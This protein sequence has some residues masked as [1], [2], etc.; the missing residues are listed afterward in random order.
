MKIKVLYPEIRT[1]QP[2]YQTSSSSLVVNLGILTTHVNTAEE[3]VYPVVRLVETSTGDV[4]SSE[5]VQVRLNSFSTAYTVS[6]LLP[7]K[8]Y[9]L[10]IDNLN[11][12]VYTAVIST[13]SNYSNVTVVGRERIFSH[14]STFFG[15]DIDRPVFEPG[16]VD[17]RK[18]LDLVNR[19]HGTAVIIEGGQIFTFCPTH[20]ITTRADYPNTIDYEPLPG[21]PLRTIIVNKLPRIYRKTNTLYGIE[22][23]TRIRILNPTASVNLLTSTEVDEVDLETYGLGPNGT[24]LLPV[25]QSIPSGL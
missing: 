12:R 21:M 20:V 22:P 4:L 19:T 16:P 8:I 9:A 5:T 24:L 1:S 6:G 13:I 18:G 25:F 11:N 14:E 2:S 3:F 17:F 15:Q 23:P 10:I 7:D